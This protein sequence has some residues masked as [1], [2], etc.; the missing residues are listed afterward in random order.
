MSFAL[1]Y[2][3]KIFKYLPTETEAYVN[4]NYNLC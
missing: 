2:N 4:A 3:W 1:K